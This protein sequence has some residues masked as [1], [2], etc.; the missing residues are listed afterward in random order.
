MSSKICDNGA[1]DK[2]HADLLEA[3]KELDRVTAECEIYLGKRPLGSDAGREP[4]SG[5]RLLSIQA[6]NEANTRHR[7]KTRA[8]VACLQAHPAKSGRR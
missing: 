6:Y 2:E 3:I 1:C 5:D 8:F 4:L 7:E